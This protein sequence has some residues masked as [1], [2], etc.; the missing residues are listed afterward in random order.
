M[1]FKN[2]LMKIFPYFLYIEVHKNVNKMRKKN[3]N[4]FLQSFYFLSWR[5][6]IVTYFIGS[7]KIYFYTITEVFYTPKHNGEKL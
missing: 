5:L 7:K 2:L 1:I 6:K 4:S 3:T